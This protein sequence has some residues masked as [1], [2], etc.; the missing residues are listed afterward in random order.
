MPNKDLWHS[1][2]GLLYAF[3]ALV[4]SSLAI[5]SFSPYFLCLIFLLLAISCFFEKNRTTQLRTLL[6]ISLGISCFFLATVRFH[7]PQKIPLKAGISEVEIS[8][9]RLSKT[10]F[11]IFWNYE[12]ILKAFYQNDQSDAFMIKNL[13][14]TVSI[15][16]EKNTSH[17]PA[18]YQYQILGKLKKTSN[19]KFVIT[20]TK[21]EPWLPIRKLYNLADWR[22]QAKAAVQKNLQQSIQDQ[23]VRSFLSGIA[24][25]EFEDRLLS[26]ELGRFGLQH[27]MAISGLHFSILS[28]LLGLFLS[29]FFSRSISA[30]VTVALMSGYFVFLGPSASV[31]RAWIAITIGLIG[32]FLQKRSYGIHSLGI[33][34]LILIL[35][36]PFIIEEIGFQF[37]FG[38]TAAILIWFSPCDSFLQHL[39]AK[40]KLTEAVK[41]DLWDQH[42][43]C[44]LHFLRQGLA[45]CLAVNLIALPLTLYH[46]HKFPVM[47]LIYNLF[48]PFLMSLSLILLVLAFSFSLMFPWLGNLLHSINESYTRFILN[49]A[50]NLPKSFDI[51]WYIDSISKEAMMI[52]ALALFACGLSLLQKKDLFDIEI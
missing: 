20:P 34:M 48:F 13:P 5:Y 51:T 2:P 23:H 47:S 52:Y 30:L 7:F 32:L 49:F 27:L 21:N 29:L 11:G 40:R 4:G 16:F 1:F 45:L 12:G 39:F 35:W 6:A 25:G 46:F 22:Y 31:T 14:V 19:G 28:S 3:A 50:F 43:Y 41:M 10:P 37:S 24:T 36:N 26:F 15:P 42:G 9:L 44:V 18:N 17:I 38:V 8:S 33:G